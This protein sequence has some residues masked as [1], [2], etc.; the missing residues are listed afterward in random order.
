MTVA[1]LL[2][3]RPIVAGTAFACAVLTTNR[4]LRAHDLPT[5]DVP[6]VKATAVAK[7]WLGVGRYAIQYAPPLLVALVLAGGRARWGRRAAAASLLL[8]TPL[9]AWATRRPAVDP[10]RFAALAL[11]D[12]MA[13]GAGVWAGCL[14]HRTTTPLRAIVRR[15]SGT[16]SG[17]Q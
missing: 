6:R 1:A 2:A 13:Y 14:R 9:A 12:D 11:A 16:R 10:I 7:T 8:G 5:A 3:R 17:S 4:T 15:D